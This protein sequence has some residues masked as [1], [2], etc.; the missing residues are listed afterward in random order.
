MMGEGAWATG[1]RW[2]SP[3]RGYLQWAHDG[4]SL[5]G[6][7]QDGVASARLG[8]LLGAV[9]QRWLVGCDRG[10]SVEFLLC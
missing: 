2:R 3:L 10:A 5:H 6:G 1:Q 7:G 4:P 8:R 9:W